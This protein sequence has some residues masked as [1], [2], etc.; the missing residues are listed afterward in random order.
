L[1]LPEPTPDSEPSWFG[2]PLSVRP[3]APFPR[4]TLTAFLEGRKIATRLL[5]AGNI[6]RQPYFNGVA[7]RVVG[8]LEN[9]DRVMR[10]TFWIGVYPGLTTPMIDYVIESFGVFFRQTTGR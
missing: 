9:C 4:E 10:D 1:I 3:G 2:F 7:H 8:G 6:T 5:F